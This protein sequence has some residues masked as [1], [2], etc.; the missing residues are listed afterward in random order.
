MLFDFFAPRSLCASLLAVA[1]LPLLAEPTAA[2]EPLRVMSFNVRYGEAPDGENAWP[3]RRELVLAVIREFDPDLLC[4]QEALRFQLDEMLA[5]M[6][7]YKQIGAGRD[8]GR[9]AGEFSA[10]FFREKRLEMRASDT[11]WLSD[12]P[13]RPGSKG[14]GN[15]ITRICTWASFV[16]RRAPPIQDDAEATLAETGAFRVYNTHWDHQSQSSRERSAEFMAHEIAEH[17]GE[18]LP[19]LVTG[20]FNAGEDNPAFRKLLAGSAKLSDTFRQL[21]PNDAQVGTFNGFM[22]RRDGP[23]IDAVLASPHWK[24]DAAEIVR[25][26]HGDRHPSDHFPVT[27]VVRIRSP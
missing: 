4:V 10:V 5:A 1:A 27:A 14:W 2:A 21:H 3:A 18:H 26:K 9:A 16:D 23:K 19:V 12:T 22:G 6:P 13:D 25:T 7:G 8:D 17:C 11:F 20:D 24:V 15:D